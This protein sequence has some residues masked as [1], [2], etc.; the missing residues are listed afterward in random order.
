VKKI[1]ELKNLI[2]SPKDNLLKAMQRLD[3]DGPKF[4]I[5]VNNSKLIGTITD[6][7]IRRAIIKGATPESLV[8]EIMNKKP[9]R[10]MVKLPKMHSKLFQSVTS[11]IKFLPIVDNN[12]ILK[13]VL[14]EEYK[15]IHKSVLIMAGGFGKRLGNLTKNRPKPLLKIGNEIILETL[16]KKLEKASFKNI[17][18]STFYLHEQIEKFIKDRPN[19]FDINIKLLQE[20]KPLGTAGSISLVPEDDRELLMII[21]ADVVSDLDFEAIAILHSEKLNDITLAVA[22]YTQSIPFGVV[23]FDKNLNFKKIREKPLIDYHIL[24]GIY[25]L[26]KKVCN[27]V[28]EKYLDM[29]SLI[30]KAHLLNCKVEIYPIYE[31]WKDIGC[32]QD[33]GQVQSQFKV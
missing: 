16:I 5:I 33:L 12:N 26:S 2:L 19:N 31:S 23:N 18:I 9:A 28:D 20:N 13:Y 8:V 27:Y 7:D 25:F 4:Q 17:Y 6:G 11:L 32:T 24:S 15:N 10:G 22:K 21:N 30:E 14:I 29:P 1:S 3:K